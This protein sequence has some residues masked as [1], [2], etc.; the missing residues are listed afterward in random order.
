MYERIKRFDVRAIHVGINL[1]R[2][3]DPLVK[4]SRACTYVHRTEVSYG[5][6]IGVARKRIRDEEGEE[7]DEP[8][9]K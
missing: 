3:R 2:A 7:E 1:P 8:R 6:S 4:R 9:D 5:A